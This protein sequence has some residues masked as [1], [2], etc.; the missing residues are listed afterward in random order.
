[1]SEAAQ[2]E[3]PQYQLNRAAAKWRNRFHRLQRKYEDLLDRHKQM[4]DDLS[5]SFESLLQNPSQEGLYH[6]ATYW[7]ERIRQ[8]E[9]K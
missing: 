6:S 9:S 3:S 1:M 8:E 2:A 5:N 7:L 4:C